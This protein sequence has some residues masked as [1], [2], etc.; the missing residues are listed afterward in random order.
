MILEAIIEAIVMFLFKFPGAFIRWCFAG[1]RKPYKD[2][3]FDDSEFNGF[4]GLVT[5]VV[6]VLGIVALTGCNNA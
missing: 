2:V 5:T 1:F 3:L 6:I 4:V